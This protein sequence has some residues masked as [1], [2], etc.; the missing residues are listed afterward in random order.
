VAGAAAGGPAPLPAGAVARGPALAPPEQLGER[1]AR[2]WVQW[3]Y[4]AQAD[5]ATG[6]SGL[7]SPVGVAVRLVGQSGCGS[8]GC[9]DGTDLHTGKPCP[10]PHTRRTGSP[11]RPRADVGG[12]PA[13]DRWECAVP[14]CRTPTKGPRPNDGRCPQCRRA[15]ADAE[16]AARELAGRLADADAAQE[17][18]RL[19]AQALAW[20]LTVEDAYAEH[21]A[22]E[23]ARARAEQ[24]R[25]QQLADAA[26]DQRIREE[27]ARQHPELLPYSP[28]FAAAP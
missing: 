22:R 11:Q 14:E 12:G 13:A 9:E 6:G 25:R 8:A 24:R 27:Y 7:A 4:A 19:Q 15:D 20:E 16:R 18:T 28:S 10:R 2:R 17:R 23:H 26:D 5:T 21:A 3:G 1:I